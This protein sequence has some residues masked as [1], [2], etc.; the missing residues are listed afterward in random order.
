MKK[1]RDEER[2]RDLRDREMKQQKGRDVETEL[3]RHGEI[4]RQRDVVAERCSDR[5][6]GETERCIDRGGET[7]K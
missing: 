3:K 1:G 7:E 2:K 5:R 6:D 4:E